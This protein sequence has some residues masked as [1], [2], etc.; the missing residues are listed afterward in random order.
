[1]LV[2]CG[3]LSCGFVSLGA[4]SLSLAGLLWDLRSGATGGPL[5]A[6][7]SRFPSALAS[8]THG[9]HGQ[10]PHSGNSGHNGLLCVPADMLGN[11]WVSA[12]SL[13]S[14]VLLAGRWLAGRWMVSV[15]AGW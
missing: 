12:W 6:A 4:I 1:M 7:H 10:T 2:S 14:L 8:Y 13:A 5:S 11:P 3:F 15:S 9:R